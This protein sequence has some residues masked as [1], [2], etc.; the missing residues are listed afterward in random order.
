MSFKELLRDIFSFWNRK[1]LMVP[2]PK[3]LMYYLGKVVELILNPPPFSSD[4]MLMMWKD[5]VCGITGGAEP[6][7]V[8]KVLRRD[9]IPYEESLRWSLEGYRKLTSS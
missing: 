9:P 5:N 2:M 3:T 6:Q 8:Q 4:Q 1:V 7:G